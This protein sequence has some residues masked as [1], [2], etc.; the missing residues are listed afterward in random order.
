MEALAD[1]TGTPAAQNSD[2]GLYSGPIV[3]I[4]RAS[5]GFDIDQNTCEM[6]HTTDTFEI[7]GAVGGE[8]VDVH[9]CGLAGD[10]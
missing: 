4:E 2:C 8:N 9:S 5:C 7:T 6:G 3:M 1:T 10:A